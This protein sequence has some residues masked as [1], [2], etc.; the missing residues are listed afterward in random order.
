MQEHHV[1]LRL[2][3]LWALPMSG[4][5]AIPS[6]LIAGT[7]PFWGGSWR[8][9]WARD[10]AFLHFSQTASLRPRSAG[11][12]LRRNVVRQ[13]FWTIVRSKGGGL[14]KMKKSDISGPNLPPGTNRKRVGS[15]DQLYVTGCWPGFSRRHGGTGVMGTL[16]KNVSYSKTDFSVIPYGYLNPYSYLVFHEKATLLRL[17]DNPEFAPNFFTYH[18]APP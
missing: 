5:G 1:P 13:L 17:F 14:G 2:P 12:V 18:A 8:Q 4:W 11:K 7:T 9:I 6:T 10:V 3:K 16:G 15:C